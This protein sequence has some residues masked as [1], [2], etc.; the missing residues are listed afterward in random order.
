[1]IEIFPMSSS[2]M[3]AHPMELVPRSSPIICFMLFDL[4]KLFTFVLKAYHNKDLFL[5]RLS[6]P[7]VSP[8]AF[9]FHLS[10]Y[11]LLYSFHCQ[12]HL[13]RFH[14][15]AGSLFSFSFSA[16]YRWVG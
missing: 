9:L 16:Q 14:S 4:R 3:R 12:K 13:K 7:L 2:K 5:W 8:G 10:F 15:N 1:M 6:L 11:L